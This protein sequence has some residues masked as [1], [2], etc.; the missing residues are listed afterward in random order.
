[1]IMWVH[2]GRDSG[3]DSGSAMDGGELEYLIIVAYN[4]YALT[5]ELLEVYR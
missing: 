4:K 2:F 5:H 3:R 1:M